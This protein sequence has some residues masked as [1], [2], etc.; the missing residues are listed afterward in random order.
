[1]HAGCE[2]AH[3]A[4]RSLQKTNGT[5]LLISHKLRQIGEMSCNPSIG[6]IGKGT[7]VKEIDSMN[8]LMGRVTDES[9]ILYKVLN[10]SKGPAVHGPRA[11]A[12]RILYKKHM[13]HEI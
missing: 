13:Q 9:G 4:A 7:L 12:D 3:A 8:G 1:G 2:A 5:V 10:K 6:G 11:Q